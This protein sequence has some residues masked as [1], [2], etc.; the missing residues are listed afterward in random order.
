[1]WGWDLA[2]W[3]CEIW[4]RLCMWGWDVALWVCEIWIRLCLCGYVTLWV[5]MGNDSCVF[6]S[7]RKQ[8]ASQEMVRLH[9]LLQNLCL[10]QKLCLVVSVCT[11]CCG[12]WVMVVMVGGGGG[13]VGI[14]TLAHTQIHTN[15]RCNLMNLTTKRC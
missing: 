2:L 7:Y 6:R 4:I 3:V 12:L 9:C 5:R 1:M 14:G 10:F 13:R 11:L 8:M 15:R